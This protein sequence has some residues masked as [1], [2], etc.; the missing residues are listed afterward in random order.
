MMDGDRAVGSAAGGRG[1]RKRSASGQT[2]KL[3]SVGPSVDATTVDRERIRDELSK[4]RT[5]S[6]VMG[7]DFIN[8]TDGD[9]EDL[10]VKQCARDRQPNV[11]I[12]P[13]RA[14]R[15]TAKQIKEW[16]N[17]L[18]HSDRTTRIEVAKEYQIVI[19]HNTYMTCTD[20]E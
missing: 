7:I 5:S 11:I 14:F 20:G 1:K 13:P 19:D 6:Y 4:K 12:F 3:I 18:G 17:D 2:K 15:R 8:M 16:F 9:I 10:L